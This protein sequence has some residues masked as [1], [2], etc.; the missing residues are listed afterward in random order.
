ML[1]LHSELSRLILDQLLGIGL[2][3]FD[4]TH[5]IQPCRKSRDRDLEGQLIRLE[6]SQHRQPIPKLDLIRTCNAP[7]GQRALT[8]GRQNAIVG[9]RQFECH[10]I[11]GG[12]GREGKVI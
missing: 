5:E 12:V 2:S 6:R 10:Y 1:L 4:H 8:L 3:V 9:V 7:C 11:R